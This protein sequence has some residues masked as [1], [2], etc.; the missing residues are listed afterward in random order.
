MRIIIKKMELNVTGQERK[1]LARDFALAFESALH[2]KTRSY[3]KGASQDAVGNQSGAGNDMAGS[4]D[5]YIYEV[6][7][8]TID[9]MEFGMSVNELG[10]DVAEQV[11]RRL[12]DLAQEA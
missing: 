2:D 4:T 10:R 1:G 9:L 3:S 7:Q 5:K 6:E 12:S 11:V 8:L